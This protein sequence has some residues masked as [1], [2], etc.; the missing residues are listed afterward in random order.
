MIE[1]EKKLMVVYLVK[2]V[3]FCVVVLLLGLYAGLSV[4]V[5]VRDK[6]RFR[7]FSLILC[8]SCSIA[9]QL[10]QQSSKQQ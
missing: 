2:T 9:Q 6:L 3:V 1:G 4:C 8:C 7:R 5:C 10:L